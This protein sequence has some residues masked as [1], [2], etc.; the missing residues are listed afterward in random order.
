MEEE[1]DRPVGRGVVGPSTRCHAALSAFHA[2]AQKGC[3]LSDGGSVHRVTQVEAPREIKDGGSL[4]A[5][6]K[7][8][9]VTVG[10]GRNRASVSTGLFGGRERREETVTGSHGSST[11]AARKK[12]EDKTATGAGLM[13]FVSFFQP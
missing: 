5:P 6:H 9:R 13:M 4:T 12:K 7:E 8:A 11:M 2:D 10:R 1:D 3:R